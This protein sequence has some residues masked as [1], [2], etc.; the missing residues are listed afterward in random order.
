MFVVEHFGD[1][2]AE[3]DTYEE[4]VDYVQSNAENDEDAFWNWD[5][6]ER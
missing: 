3:F 2:V 6:Y 4:A 5:I 1:E